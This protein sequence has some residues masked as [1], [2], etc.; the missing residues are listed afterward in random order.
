M[1]CPI[2][3]FSHEGYIFEQMPFMLPQYAI[4]ASS[5]LDGKYHAFELLSNGT[6]KKL[7]TDD[8]N[9]AVVTV[10]RRARNTNRKHFKF[11]WRAKDADGVEKED[12]PTSPVVSFNCEGVVTH[13]TFLAV[14]QIVRV[15]PE[16]FELYYCDGVNEKRAIYRDTYSGCK[17][18]ILDAE[19]AVRE[20]IIE[21]YRMDGGL[22]LYRYVA[23]LCS[24]DALKFTGYADAN[25]AVRDV[26]N[27]SESW[28]TKVCRISRLG[29]N[30]SGSKS[31]YYHG[32]GNTDWN[33]T[34]LDFLCR[35]TNKEVIFLVGQGYISPIMTCDEFEKAILTYIREPECEA[36]RAYVAACSSHEY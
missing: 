1:R 22:H 19:Q 25:E 14:W 18:F 7:T 13:N 12:S 16:L 20:R 33:V 36:R 4:Y 26:I 21:V 11:N 10:L 9:M 2:T 24:Y 17:R 34:Q 6:Y 31:L 29:I 28:V 23:D 15:E 5:K 35:L 3:Y 8:Y 30:D 32:E 27:Y